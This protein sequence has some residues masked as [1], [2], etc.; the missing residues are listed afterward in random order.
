MLVT[1][2]RSAAALAA[3]FGLAAAPGCGSTYQSAW[4]EPDT[5]QSQQAATPEGQSR[6][7][8][9]VGQ[10]DAAWE[11]RDD[12]EQI[13]AAITAWEQAVELDGNDHETW[14][15][16][17]RAYYFLADG[18]LRFSDESAM[19]DTYQSAIRAAERALR[20]LSPEFAQRMAAGEARRS[21]GGRAHDRERRPAALLARGRA[22]KVGAAAGLRD[23]PLPTRTRSAP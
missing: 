22:R 10:G 19:G 8:E 18:H 23:R 12:P 9:L 7:A 11:R 3:L 1:T 16:I 2:R 13:R 21:G 6:R 17:S 14:T 5:T 4:D 20:A 15:K